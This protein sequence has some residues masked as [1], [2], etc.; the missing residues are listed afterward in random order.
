[1]ENEQR[2]RAQVTHT[3]ERLQT[4]QLGLERKLL[5]KKRS[6]PLTLSKGSKTTK[7]RGSIPRPVYAYYCHITYLFNNS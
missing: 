2:V 3:E 1:M 4:D 5:I 6:S 7:I